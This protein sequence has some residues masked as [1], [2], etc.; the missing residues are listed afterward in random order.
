MEIDFNW[1]AILAGAIASMFS[2]MIWYHPKVFGTKWM[3]SIG[4][5]KKDL[6]SDQTKAMFIAI[7]RSLFLSFTLYS[8]IYVTDYFYVD[9]S[10]LFNA[11]STGMLVSIPV[12]G[13]TMLMHDTFEKRPELTTKIHVLYEIF[14]IILVSVVIGLIAG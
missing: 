13:M 3:K 14:T 5:T 10:F 1:L 12:V 9:K 4:L 7:L 2:G 6:E 8:L 11:F